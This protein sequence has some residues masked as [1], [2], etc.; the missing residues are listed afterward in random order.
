MYYSAKIEID[1][2]QITLIKKQKPTK[3][4]GK[5]LDALS[6]GQLSEKQEQETFTA[7]NILQQLS[8][9]LR[10][11]NIK[12]II[13][14]S[15]DDYDFYLDD[16]G[17][18]DDLSQ[19]MFHLKA[20]IDPLESEIFKTIY[21]VLEHVEDNIKYLIE[22]GVERKHKVGEYPIKIKVNG[23]LIEYKYERGDTVESLE[24]RLAE[25]FQTQKSY[26]KY[27]SNIKATFDKFIDELDNGIRK[28]IKVDDV[29]K[30]TAVNI[31]RPKKI[32]NSPNEI[33][34]QH[35][36]QPIFYG[37][38]GLEQYFFYC[39]LWA[40]LCYKYNIYCSN[41]NLVDES[42]H[43]IITLGENGFYAGDT[44]TL[45]IDKPFEIPNTGDILYYG[46]NE[47]ARQFADANLIDSDGK[48]EFDDNNVYHDKPE[49]D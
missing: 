46:N 48:V 40:N 22:I 21:M 44:D 19:A 18:E 27:A 2:S 7:L 32:L 4:F 28:V 1:P 47:Y 14:L 34:H 9:G 15:I 35:N 17:E 33:K 49:L 37:Y 31:I 43:E 3:L 25:V 23:V 24:K 5:L 45:N 39:W 12:N 26:D 10:G 13:R 30:T 36:E 41:F 16:T 8:T 29:R 42:G 6:L 38:F 20:K 11:L